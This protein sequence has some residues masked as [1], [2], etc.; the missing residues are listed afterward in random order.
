MA[1][2]DDE[3]AMKIV[4]RGIYSEEDGDGR[5][6]LALAELEAREAKRKQGA[7]HARAAWN[8]L[9]ESD[10]PTVELL[11]A[12]DLG[13]R[14]FI[15]GENETQARALA[16]DLTRHLPLHGDAWRIRA[17][18]ELSL[19][20]ASDAKR[21]IDKATSLAPDNARVHAMRGQILLRF[22]ARKRAIPAFE[23]ALELGADL[24]DAERW[25]KLLRQS[26]R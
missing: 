10:R 16:R 2:R 5:L 9:K 8:R 20:E 17:R 4:R 14:L 19:N 25:R 24:P 3:E 18:T 1:L 26:K 21:S 7:L 23:R 6:F 12:A 15:R 13:T 11:A 22:G